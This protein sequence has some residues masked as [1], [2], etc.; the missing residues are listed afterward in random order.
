MDLPRP[1]GRLIKLKKARSSSTKNK[2]VALERS[3]PVK[4]LRIFVSLPIF[5]LFLFEFLR[6][7]IRRIIYHETFVFSAQMF[8]FSARI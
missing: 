2:R 6:R 5:V 7:N 8:V 4:G 1:E 3:E